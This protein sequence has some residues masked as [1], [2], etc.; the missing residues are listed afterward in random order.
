MHLQLESPQ[1]S[2]RYTSCWSCDNAKQ[3]QNK[4]AGNLY[5][6]SFQ[7]ILLYNC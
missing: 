3:Q 4:V 2:S 7:Q 6:G 5:I 1:Y